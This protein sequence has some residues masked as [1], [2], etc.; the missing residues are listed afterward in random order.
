M[1]H[2]IEFVTE[3]I[4]GCW[5][6]NLAVA[7]RTQNLVTPVW[8]TMLCFQADK[9]TRSHSRPTG[10]KVQLQFLVKGELGTTACAYSSEGVSHRCS[11]T[12]IRVGEKKKLKKPD[13]VLGKLFAC[14]E[15]VQFR[16]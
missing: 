11:Y 14:L 8:S 16:L 12:R 5:D 10:T 2:K 1:L 13:K 15:A 6:R 3:R 9:R 4:K 7:A